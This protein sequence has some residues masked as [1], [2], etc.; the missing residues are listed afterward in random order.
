MGRS[1]E[2]WDIVIGETLHKRRGDTDIGKALVKDKKNLAEF[3]HK[4]SLHP[5]PDGNWGLLINIVSKSR[6]Q[7]EGPKFPSNLLDCIKIKI[8]LCWRFNSIT[9]RRILALFV[10]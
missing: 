7:L 10:C 9:G 6:H 1:R 3:E 8:C 4:Y 2:T 5:S